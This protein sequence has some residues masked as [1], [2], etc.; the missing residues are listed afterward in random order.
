MRKTFFLWCLIISLAWTGCQMNTEGDSNL[1]FDNE[2]EPVQEKI[3][4]HSP[5]LYVYVEGLGVQVMESENNGW[6]QYVI[7]SQ[8]VDV[9]F[10][11]SPDGNDA[12]RKF[13]VSIGE[14]WYDKTLNE[15]ID[16]KPNLD[17]GENENTLSPPVGVIAEYNIED[18]TI[19]IKWEAVDNAVD[20]EVYYSNLNDYSSAELFMVTQE[21]TT[22][23]FDLRSDTVYYFWVKAK[24]NDIVSDFSTSISCSVPG[25]EE[26]E[27]PVPT[28]ASGMYDPVDDK[29]TITWNAVDGADRYEIYYNT[30]N[31]SDEALRLCVE[32]NCAIVITDL[33]AGTT[34][35]FWI[36]ALNDSGISDFSDCVIC[37]VP[38]ILVAP[39]G[40]TAIVE[41]TD[42]VMLSWNPVAEATE[43][44][45]YYSK[46]NDCFN[47]NRFTVTQKTSVYVS[48]LEAGTVFY[49]WVKAVSGSRVSDFSIV[50]SAQTGEEKPAPLPV[51]EITNIELTTN[52]D[53][54]RI[55]WQSVPQA[56][57]YKIYRSASKYSS[58]VEIASNITHTTYDDISV[59]LKAVGSGYYYSVSVVSSEGIE[60][61]LSEPRGITVRAP[62]VAV[63]LAGWNVGSTTKPRYCAPSYV[64]AKIGDIPISK[65]ASSPVSV[66]TRPTIMISNYYEIVPGKQLYQTRYRVRSLTSTIS[67]EWS[68]PVQ[69]DFKMFKYKINA[70]TGTITKEECLLIMD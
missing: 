34:Y 49:F 35:Y 21:T 52:E 46:Y 28:G 16:S 3:I 59:D 42:S 18:S 58:R 2:Q 67:G 56:V 8:S 36:R 45:I 63:Y 1:A 7:E 10:M 66:T 30:I 4:L 68:Q 44:E 15:I 55:T 37:N 14:W 65:T 57:F 31:S 61:S 32:K 62:Q 20:Y 50:C 48:G 33:T 24:N 40:V 41:S 60:S 27:L 38:D 6:Y 17:S 25:K 9:I 11:Y 39:S 54:L 13:T 51:P 43:Y 23:F 69:Y 5:M 64:A 47:A 12:S 53:G 70:K 29:I 26:L 22:F 19:Q